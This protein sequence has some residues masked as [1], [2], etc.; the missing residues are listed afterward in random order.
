MR[1]STRSGLVAAVPLLVLFGAYAAYWWIVAGRIEDGVVAW[2]KSIQTRNIDASW[3][4]LH[5][6]GFPFDLRVELQDATLRDRA[7]S[8]APELWLPVLTGSARPW[9]FNVWQLT[10][11]EGLAANLAAASGRPQ[12]KLAAKTGNGTVALGPEGKTLLWLNFRDVGAEAGGRVPIQSAVTW[13]T[14]P[15]SPPQAHTEPSLGLAF[16]LRK[17]HLPASPPSFTDMIDQAAFGVTVKGA[18]P[19]GPLVQAIA[20]WRDA[21]GTVEL[22]NLHLEWGGVGVNATGTVALDQDLQPMGAFS[23]GIEGFGAILKALVEAGR[24]D[25][26]QA[27]LAQIAL[28]AFA[29]PGLDGKPQIKTSFTIQNG[30]MFLGPVKLGAA[31]RIVWK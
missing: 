30:E 9:N 14:L 2:R 22:D 4:R 28:T 6:D 20:A 26:E 24:L 16:D 23:G 21:G 11:P 7:L 31:P 18:V 19:D 5:I 3:R 17:I 10:A 1:R 15:A 13:I 25:T 12:L 29:K 27:A 8:P